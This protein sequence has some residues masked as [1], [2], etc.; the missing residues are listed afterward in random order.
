MFLKKY[1]EDYWEI[2]KT[3]ST[4][5]HKIHTNYTNGV[6]IKRR[7]VRWIALNEIY[8][9]KRVSKAGRGAL[10]NIYALPVMLQANEVCKTT[11]AEG[12]WLCSIIDA[13][14]K[15]ECTVQLQKILK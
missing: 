8:I 5:D 12:F 15:D 2:W 11:Q 13:W 3:T 4:P 7:W 6:K 9:R 10:F 1:L 14:Q